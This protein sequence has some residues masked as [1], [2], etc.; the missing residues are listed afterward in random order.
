MPI[1]DDPGK[2]LNRLQEQLL[3]DEDWEKF[4]E[5]YCE[6][7]SEE[8]YEEEY[9]EESD[10]EYE[11]EPEEYLPPARSNRGLVLLALAELAGI[12]LIAA[13]WLRVLL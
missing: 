4:I 10:E 5:E 13:Y 12:G 2:E 6:E 8:E 1:F 3:E 9:D 7:D 11:D